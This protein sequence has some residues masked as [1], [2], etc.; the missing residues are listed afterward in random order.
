L[1]GKINK[2]KRTTKCQSRNICC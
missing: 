2:A 1:G